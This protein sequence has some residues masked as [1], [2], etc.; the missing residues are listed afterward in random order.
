[1]PALA[2]HDHAKPAAG[3]RAAAD[4]ATDLAATY[5]MHSKPAAARH[6]RETADLNARKAEE[7]ERATLNDHPDGTVALVTYRRISTRAVRYLVREAGA[8]RLRIGAPAFITD[9]RVVSV[10]PLNTLPAGHVAIRRDVVVSD[11]DNV[12]RWA[13][14]GDVPLGGRRILRAFADAREATS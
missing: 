4:L 8:W 2:K 12:R 6:W 3:F 11:D 5:E 14:D 13:D 9:D 10:E 7:A 1:M